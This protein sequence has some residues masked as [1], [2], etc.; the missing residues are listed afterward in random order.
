M[1]LTSA[2]HPYR[3]GAR[4]TD[5]ERLSVLVFAGTADVTDAGDSRGPAFDADVTDAGDSRGLAFNADV[6]DAGDSRGLA[7]NAD[8]TDDGDS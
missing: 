2:E 5:S 8:V 1:T 7:F 6:T 3:C 4:S